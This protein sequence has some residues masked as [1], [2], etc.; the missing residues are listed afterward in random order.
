MAF[1]IFRQ[2]DAKD[3]GPACLKMIAKFFGKNYSLEYLRSSTYLNREGVSLLGLSVAAEK[4]GFRTLA[5]KSDFKQLFEEVPL[6][7]ILHWKQKHFIVLPPQK[8]KKKITIADPSHGMVRVD[9]DT[10]TS[11][12]TG[13]TLLLEPSETFFEKEGESDKKVT[14]GFAFLARYLKTYKKYLTQLIISIVVG[15]ILSLIVPFLTQSLVDYGINH[16]NIGFVYLILI[17]Q[18]VIFAGTSAIEIIRSWI[19]LHINS[20]INISIISDFL[21]KLMKLPIRFFDTK[22]VGDINQRI[23]DHQ[24]IQDFLTGST[25]SVLFS[26]VN[27]MVLIVVLSIYS[28]TIFLTFFVFSIASIIWI[29]F[30]LKKRKDL[31]YKRFQS[32]SENDSSIY[33]LISGMQEIKLNN[34]EIPR[35]WEWERIQAKLYRINVKSLTLGQYQQV[36]SMIFNQ[37]KNILVSFLSA[38]EVINGHITLGMMLSISYIIG[39][40]NGPLDQLLAFIHEAQDAKLSLERLSEVHNINEEELESDIMGESMMSIGKGDISIQNLSFQY[41]GPYSPMVLKNI[42]LH[43]QSGKITA[44]VGGSGSGKTTLLKLLLKFYQPVEGKILIDKH[45]LRTFSASWWRSQCGSVMQEGFIFSDTIARNIAISDEV[46][47]EKK[48]IHSASVSNINEFIEDLPLGYKTKIGMAGNGISTGQR[49][50]LQIARAVYKNPRYLFFDEATSALDSNNEKV[51]M[52]NLER[53]YEGRTV[54]VIAHRLSTVKNA[55]LI[56]VLNK[57]EI[58]ETG[59]HETLTANRGAYYHLVKN[60]LELDA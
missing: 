19:L 43:I 7:C 38:K 54:V 58:V 59:T 31:D 35:R 55:D 53:F 51:I 15:T 2:L 41:D 5:I 25:L 45:D 12:W 13:T 16:K 24:R 28:L 29:F 3:C 20:R 39:Q 57:G 37:L 40:M 42:D 9:H 23:S 27:L 36:G 11:C 34:C 21:I 33:E 30:F 1:P 8:L 47:D 49:Q 60:Q 18:L 14:N 32:M 50:R 46:V 48:L 22:H 6:P 4:I 10:F 17:S 44:I 56:V 52:E 26:F